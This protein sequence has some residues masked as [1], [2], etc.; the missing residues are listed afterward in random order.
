MYMC[1]YIYIYICIYT[2]IVIAI[3][4]CSSLRT[5]RGPAG[6]VVHGCRRISVHRSCN[7]T[8]SLPRGEGSVQLHPTRN[9]RASQFKD[10]KL[11]PQDLDES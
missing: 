9:A 5:A 3:C 1:I 6:R 10:T 11:S 7:V 2:H 8:P 4:H